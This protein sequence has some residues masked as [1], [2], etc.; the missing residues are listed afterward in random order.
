MKRKTSFLQDFAAPASALPPTPLEESLAEA[1]RT[2]PGPAEQKTAPV[3][4]EETAGTARGQRGL[5]KKGAALLCG[6]LLAL[7]LLCAFLLELLPGSTGVA[8]VDFEYSLIYDGPLL[9]AQGETAALCAH[10][11]V[12]GQSYIVELP[13]GVRLATPTGKIGPSKLKEGALLFVS[14]AENALLPEMDPPH[15]LPDVI[16]TKGLN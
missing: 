9:D 13:D 14:A 8:D 3:P 7:A 6:A 12:S 16:L 15:I 2:A 5:G 11:P 10:D 4:S 1:A